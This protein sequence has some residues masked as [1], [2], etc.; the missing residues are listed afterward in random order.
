MSL[1]CLQYTVQVWGDETRVLE[2]MTDS[3]VLTI[4]YRPGRKG[5]GVNGEEES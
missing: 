1:H 5:L 3:S 4:F 2:L